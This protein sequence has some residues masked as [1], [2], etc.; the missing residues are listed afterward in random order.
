MSPA[1]GP[2]N[3]YSTVLFVEK[4]GFDPLLAAA[5]IAARFD[6]AI[7]STKGMSVTAARMLLDRL[8]PSIERVLVLHDFDISGFSIFGTLAADTRRYRFAN[9]VS[10][11]DLGLRLAG[12]LELELQTEPIKPVG[13]DEWQKRARTLRVHGAKP[14]EITFLRH[15]RVELNAMTADVFVAFLERKL[16]ALG[17]GK[18]VPDERVMERHA[19]RVL[20]RAMANRRLEAMRAEIEAKAAAAVLP[21]DLRARV[22]ALL[23]QERELPWD[24][25]VARVV[26]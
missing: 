5:Q 1:I 14:R 2:A 9:K 6:V 25:A 23:A 17:V 20:E 8:G 26:T 22:A 18:L 10:I 11:V 4:E 7:M 24:L 3:R 15:R 12:V 19:R 21:K 16:T 13:D